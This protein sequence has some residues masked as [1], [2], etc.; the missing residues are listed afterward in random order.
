MKEFF[1]NIK[2]DNEE[3]RNLI[4]GKY[5]EAGSG[6]PTQENIGGKN[7]HNNNTNPIHTQSISRVFNITNNNAIII[8]KLNNKK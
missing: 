1:E 5:E 8:N 6:L 3:L 2:K 4:R 7:N